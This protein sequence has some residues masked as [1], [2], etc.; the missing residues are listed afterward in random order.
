[1]NFPSEKDDWKKFDRNNVIIALN[2]CM[3]K[4]KKHVLLM[5]ENM[6]QIGKNKLLF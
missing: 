1:M 5:F 2:F 6:T 3:L 4:K